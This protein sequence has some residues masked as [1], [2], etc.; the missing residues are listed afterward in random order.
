MPLAILEL[1]LSSFGTRKKNCLEWNFS[2][3]PLQ[4]TTDIYILRKTHNVQIC[5]ISFIPIKFHNDEIK[6][7]AFDVIIKYW[8]NQLFEVV[9]YKIT[10]WKQRPWK[11]RNVKDLNTWSYFPSYQAALV[12]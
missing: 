11:S 1:F 5:N 3:G 8:R 12:S 7:M 9:V 6:N 4:I 10:G 2:P